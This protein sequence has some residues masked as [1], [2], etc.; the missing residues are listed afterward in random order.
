[1][2]GDGDLDI[3]A[4]FRAALDAGYAGP[5][6]LEMVGP[7]I[8]AEGHDGALRRAIPRANALLEEVMP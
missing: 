8:D 7:L 1:V 2:P 4:F 3:A 5:F 6:E